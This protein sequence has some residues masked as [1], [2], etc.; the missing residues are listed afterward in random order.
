MTVAIVGPGVSQMLISGVVHGQ[1]YRRRA[2]ACL[3]G[4]P[5]SAFRHGTTPCPSASAIRIALV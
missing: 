4:S 5:A 1:A 3:G 2:A